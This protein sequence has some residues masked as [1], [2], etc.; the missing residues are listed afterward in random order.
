MSPRLTTDSGTT[1]KVEVVV[2]HEALAHLATFRLLPPLPGMACRYAITGKPSVPILTIGEMPTSP[3]ESTVWLVEEAF[4]ALTDAS[5]K[6][7]SNSFAIRVIFAI[8][9]VMGRAGDT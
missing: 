5:D 8:G 2:E 6:S 3:I 1:T 4:V 9:E 7:S